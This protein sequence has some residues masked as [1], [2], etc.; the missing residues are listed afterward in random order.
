[1]KTEEDINLNIKEEDTSD[2]TGREKQSE[3]DEEP[4]GATKEKKRAKET[5]RDDHRSKEVK[6]PFITPLDWLKT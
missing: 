5:E 1:M 2:E 6:T 4:D 3:T